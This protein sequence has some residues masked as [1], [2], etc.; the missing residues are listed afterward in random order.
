MKLIRVVIVFLCLHGTLLAQNK[1]LLYDFVEIPQALMLNPGIQTDF[2][3]YAGVPLISGI[4]GYAGSSGIAPNAIFANDGV[5]INLK[6]RERMLNALSIRDEFS[7]NVQIE[8]FSGGFRGANPNEF[9]SFGAYLEVDNILYWP[10][11]YAFLIMDGNVGQLNRRFNLSDLSTRGSMVNVVHFGINK[12]MGRKLTLGGRAKYYAGLMDYNS[13]NNNGFL[14]NREGQNNS[15][16]ST[17]SADLQ[18][19]TSGL[20]ELSEADEGAGLASTLLRRT[21]FGGDMGLGVDLGFSYALTE[22]TLVTGSVLD[23]GF[24]YHSGDVESYS[25]RGNATVEGIEIDILEDFANLNRDFWQD[26]VDEVEEAIPFETSNRAY[27]TFRPTKVYGSIRHGF[28]KQVGQVGLDCDCTLTGDLG[29]DRMLRYRNEVGGQLFLIQRPRGPQAA[30][31]AFYLRRL[32]N[33]LAL[34][35]TYTADKFSF[36]NVGLGLNLQAGPINFYAMADNL[37]SYRN[38][39][40]SQYA[41]FQLGLNIISWGR[42]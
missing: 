32:G 13:T 33:V 1:Q 34:K 19:R 31:T 17:L 9:Y 22:K 35:A 2:K 28:G 7:S 14:V 25:L 30:L 5:D 42:N 26:L 18:L 23:L 29:N 16:A 21:F 10:R 36:A 3:W 38:I 37:L 24:I 6:V 11:D 40:G 20:N 27:V 12:K 41:S 39:A 8:W 4:S 15:L